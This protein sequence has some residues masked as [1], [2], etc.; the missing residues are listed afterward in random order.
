MRF[1]ERFGGIV[2]V[3][4]FF[5]YLFA[6][7]LTIFYP[8]VVTVADEDM[9][10]DVH[11]N[12][13]KVP[14]YTPAEAAGQQ[15]Y[16]EQVC[17]HCHSQFV[18]P[19]MDED[20]RWGPVS[21]AGESAIDRPHLF[22]TRRI[23][24]DL[25]R[26]GGLRNDDWQIA[27]LYDPRSTVSESVMPGFTWLFRPN[28]NAEEVERLIALYD[29][30]GNGAVEPEFDKLIAPLP[31]DA[32]TVNRLA[33]ADRRGKEASTV[34]QDDKGNDLKPGADGRRRYV[35]AY[36]Q[37]AG[38]DGRP[39]TSGDRL[40]NGFDGAPLPT[41]AALNLVAYLQ[42]LGTS[43]GPWRQPLA[44]PTPVRGAK[45]S[46]KGVTTTY[47][48][49]AGQ[50]QETSIEDGL[51]PRRERSRRLYGEARAK[52]T[53]QA[54]AAAED[55]ER[56]YAALMGAWRKANPEWNE[57]LTK[58]EALYVEH[59]ASC[60]GA[61]GRGNGPGARFLSVRPRDF[62]QAAYRYRST[63][64]GNLPLDGDLY[65]TLHRGLPGTSMPS[66][67]ELDPE[68]IWLLVDYVQTFLE[69]QGGERDKEFDDQA[70]ALT[71]PPVPR[72]T[73][74]K[75][76]ALIRRGK[77]VYVAGKCSNCHGT[78]GRGDGPGWDT[79]LG[80]G[81]R[82]RARD[83]KPRFAGDQPALRIRGGAY[84]HDLYRTIFTG[85]AGSA[86]PSSLRDFEEGWRLAAEADRLK[87]AGAA[88]EAVAKAE[89]AAR[90]SLIVPLYEDDLVAQHGVIRETDAQGNTVEH[91]DRLRATG[92]GQ[93]GD[94]W[95]LVFYVMD[96]L[97]VRH[98]IPLAK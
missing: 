70:A 33:G 18:R 68:Q 50:T 58:G 47:V 16:R 72:V 35:D 87:A 38:P 98:L 80:N 84:P 66:W 27:H 22:G 62:T 56:D 67:R 96:L 40:V 57:R 79:E 32:E 2:L 17:W 36:T 23:G 60:H 11:G 4:G 44:A 41:E 19:V 77:A 13:V 51:L 94:D 75:L 15:V 7:G 97:Q 49:A 53:P 29:F 26:E 39:G 34:K 78:E 61:E 20:R 81:G 69:D 5:C 3:G 76:D 37:V 31:T 59:C 86:M 52:A 30:D 54:L 91:L 95:A 65:R 89:Q 85:L 93:V 10:V 82:M 21:Q 74:A 9:V 55:A 48:D 92:G 14:P 63:Q 12:R 43:I 83:L 88:P 8:L 28:A 46:M 1:Y 64:V 25:A 90:R 71:L 73:A 24:P 6:F 42:R 45:P